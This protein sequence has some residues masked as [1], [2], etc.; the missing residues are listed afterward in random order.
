MICALDMKSVDEERKRLLVN[1]RAGEKDF[2]A[3]VGVAFG[4]TRCVLPLTLE[5]SSS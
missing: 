3:E 4:K 5:K 1:L 2:T